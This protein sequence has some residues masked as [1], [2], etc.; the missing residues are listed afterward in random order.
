MSKLVGNPKLWFF[1]VQYYQQLNVDS[2]N[3]KN[4]FSH[5]KSFENRLQLIIWQSL[6]ACLEPIQII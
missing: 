5:F 2:V 3:F 1:Q 4:G 6:D